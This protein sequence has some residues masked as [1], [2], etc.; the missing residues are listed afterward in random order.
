MKRYVSLLII[1]MLFLSGPLTF[2]IGPAQRPLQ[3]PSFASKTNNNMKTTF[4]LS[5]ESNNGSLD[6]LQAGFYR[7]IDVYPSGKRVV[8]GVASFGASIQPRARSEEYKHPLSSDDVWISGLQGAFLYFGP[9][10]INDVKY[11]RN[12]ILV[13]KND[14]T[15]PEEKRHWDL[16]LGTQG[17]GASIDYGFDG[18]EDIIVPNEYNIPIIIN[19]T[20]GNI[21]HTFTRSD[22]EEE[23]IKVSAGNID[24]DS[25]SEIV[26]LYNKTIGTNELYLRIV[27][28]WNHD[29]AEIKTIDV[30]SL[31]TSYG[32]TLFSMYS[33]LHLSDIDN[34]G[35]AEIILTIKLKVYDPYY[36]NDYAVKCVVFVFDDSLANFEKISEI[37]DEIYLLLY[38]AFAD[39]TPNAIA[40]EFDNDGVSELI[41]SFG[42]LYYFEYNTSTGK[43][44]YIK[45][46][47]SPE[48]GAISAS[49][50]LLAEDLDLDYKD[51]LIVVEPTSS[52][53][54]VFILD[55]N[56]TDIETVH[57]MFDPLLLGSS[58]MP[59]INAIVGNFDDDPYLE[60][61]VAFHIGD[62]DIYIDN[63]GIAFFGDVTENYKVVSLEYKKGKDPIMTPVLIPVSL[64][65]RILL[66]YTGLH[67]QSISAPY[68]IAAMAAPPTVEGISQNYESTSTLFGTAV[69]KTTTESN[70]Y[71]VSTGVTLSFEAGDIFKIVDIHASVTLSRELSKTHTVA[72]TIQECREFAGDFSH[73]YVIFETVTYDNYYYEVLVHP[74]KTVIGQIMAISV[75]NTPTVY[76]WTVEYFNSHNEDYPD[77]GSE[78]FNHTIGKVW[79][80]LT[81]EDVAKLE[82]KYISKGFWKSDGTMT[83]GSGQGV[84]SIEI[85][86]EEE[87][88]TEITTTIGVEFEAGVAI[89]GVGLSVSC[90]LSSSYMYSISIGR[91]TKYRGDIGDIDPSDYNTYKYSVGLVV[92]N[93]YREKDN[94]AYQVVNY[95]VE[96]Y[97]GPRDSGSTDFGNITDNS[98][99]SNII[100]QISEITGLSPE[101]V[102]LGLG[103]VTVIGIGG[104][105]FKAIHRGG[106]RRK[107]SKKRKTRRRK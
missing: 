72:Q 10:Y 1:A 52:S 12:R 45:Y 92:Y 61:A 46:L 32:G 49:P 73:D 98:V 70:G 9:I 71:T 54:N 104:A 5:N 53:F 66:H 43:I 76:K 81:R 19:G 67:N 28:D 62:Y 63:K 89:A 14:S 101:I 69:S 11:Y 95:W 96:D 106:K 103:A 6:T 94:L 31:I 97:T 17:F 68:I 51:E 65:G 22:P 29:F 3:N 84:N 36:Y 8:R 80:Y 90:G 41:V 58:V 57:S 21:L 2:A 60:F 42:Y 87:E 93:F 39:I 25:Y 85:N 48:I 15:T 75:P 74:N 78:T 23:Y 55:L 37:S 102:V 59:R 38:S 88:T 105:L 50:V 47:A 24:S 83:V 7:V 107:A 77:I 4:E 30:G 99:F 20:N 40:G 91:S 26:F 27:D 34:D 35:R 18:I 86:L 13:F 64:S 82:S 100:S 33:N 44:D 56:S 16:H 79:T